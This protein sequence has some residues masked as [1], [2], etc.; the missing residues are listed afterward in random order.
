MSHPGLCL[1]IQERTRLVSWVTMATVVLFFL[2]FYRVLSVKYFFQSYTVY[3][4]VD[5]LE[6]NPFCVHTEIGV[7]MIMGDFLVCKVS[8]LPELDL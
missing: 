3:D 5:K 6:R 7:V 8:F 1:Q 4:N 2:L